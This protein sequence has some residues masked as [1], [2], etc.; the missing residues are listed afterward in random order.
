MSNDVTARRAELYALLGDLPPR[1]RA[2]S[3]TRVARE[4]RAGYLLE[5]LALD[6]NGEE[7]VPAYFVKPPQRARVPAILYNHAHGGD[8]TLGKDELLR[9]R[10]EL[11]A[12]AYADA[13][14]AA[15]IAALRI[16][17]W[18]FGERRG[19]SEAEQGAADAWQLKRYASGHFETAAMRGEAMTFLRRWLA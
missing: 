18:G 13:L 6:L 12:P 1:D 11:Q 4:E 2:M 9:G 3:V 8:Y 19:R 15:G 5:T 7:S 17:H 10:K 16:D 14:A